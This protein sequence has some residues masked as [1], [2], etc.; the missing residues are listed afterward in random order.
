[1]IK[2]LSIITKKNLNFLTKISGFI[3]DFLIALFL[4]ESS[5]STSKYSKKLDG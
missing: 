4:K 5:K 1:L 3:D 2:A